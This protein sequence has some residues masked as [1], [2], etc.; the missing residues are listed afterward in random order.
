MRRLLLFITMIMVL[1]TLFLGCGED[2]KEATL[3]R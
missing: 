2:K 3:N 1:A